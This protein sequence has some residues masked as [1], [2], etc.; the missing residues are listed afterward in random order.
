MTE[1]PDSAK[2]HIDAIR[3]KLLE[4]LKSGAAEQLIARSHYMKYG[5]SEGGPLLD[6]TPSIEHPYQ[7]L[8]GMY[9]RLHAAAKHDGVDLRDVVTHFKRVKGGEWTCETRCVSVKEYEKFVES[10]QPIV[11]EVRVQLRSLVP[12]EPWL[13]ISF[14]GKRVMFRLED[15]SRH[16]LEPTEGLL[17]LMG[18]FEEA[19]QEKGLQFTGG[20]WRINGDMEDAE[21]EIDSTV[22]VI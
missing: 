22:A 15:G 17:A 5:E 20:S 12:G 8:L 19:A 6:A 16:M 4:C 9:Q 21:G 14:N 10:V 18:Q 13:F 2:E 11:E 1:L 3:S 7:Q